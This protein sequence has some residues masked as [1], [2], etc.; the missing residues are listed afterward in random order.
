MNLMDGKSL[1]LS[2]NNIFQMKKFCILILVLLFSCKQNK[3]KQISTSKIDNAK[4]SNATDYKFQQNWLKNVFN[5]TINIYWKNIIK[6]D[7]LDREFKHIVSNSFPLKE[8]TILFLGRDKKYGHLINKAYSETLSEHERAALGYLALLYNSLS[9]YDTATDKECTIESALNLGEP[10]SKQY[11]SFMRF[12][13]QN[14]ANTLKKIE[15]CYHHSDESSSVLYFS[16][17][18][19][20]VKANMIYIFFKGKGFGQSWVCSW[21]GKVVFLVDKQ[22]IKLIEKKESKPKYIYD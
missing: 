11:K 20:K 17:I 1:L 9:K 19:L 21:D 14:D 5:D 3:N 12:L 8:K 16:E 18:K 13:F 2:L 6:K 7:S 22:N 10:C 4:F 15:E